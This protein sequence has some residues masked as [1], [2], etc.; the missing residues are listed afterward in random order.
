MDWDDA[1]ANSPYIAGAAEYPARWAAAAA[2]FRAR[3]PATLNLRYGVH[4]RET[5]DLFRPVGEATGLF[6]FIHGG[7]WLAFGK[8][9]WSHLAA[10]ALARGWAVAIPGYPLCPNVRI[11]EITR[12]IGRAVATAAAQ[13]PGAI[14][15]SGHSAGGHLA[16]RLACA[17]AP[18]AADIR[19]RLRR[20][21]PISGLFDLAPLMETRMNA[22]LRLDAVEA[23]AESPAHLKPATGVDVV[24]WVG[25]DERPEFHRQARALRTHWPHVT[26]HVAPHRHHFDVIEALG[27]P[28]SAMLGSMLA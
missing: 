18:L 26:T 2:A 1:F 14:V 3:A 21:A 17:N 22:T 19:E 23:A 7:Y 27:D 15:V 12:A 5:L 9:D 28:D 6:V 24:A 11:A 20:A 13:V 10:G 25:A 4:P 8:D 16:A